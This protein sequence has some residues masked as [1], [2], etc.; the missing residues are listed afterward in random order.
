MLKNTDDITYKTILNLHEFYL[1]VQ[2]LVQTCEYALDEFNVD[3]TRHQLSKLF[4]R[5][6]LH[7]NPPNG[8]ADLHWRDLSRYQSPETEFAADLIRG[9]IRDVLTYQ[10]TKDYVGWL[11]GCVFVGTE[12]YELALGTL[13]N[14]SD[15][16]VD[17]TLIYG[18]NNLSC[19]D[20]TEGILD[21]SEVQLGREIYEEG[22]NYWIAGTGV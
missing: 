17:Q 4:R 15:M 13:L 9:A 1:E 18:A 22:Y 7:V 21:T 16:Y 10:Q 14:V 19:T 8:R 2:S 12:L 5:N 11:T 3:L 20:F 6:D